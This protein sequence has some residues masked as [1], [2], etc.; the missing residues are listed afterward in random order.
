MAQP[1][2]PL[3][4]P[5]SGTAEQR[6][7]QL[8]DAISRKQDRTSEPIYASVMLLAPNGATWRV[9]VDNTGALSTAVVPR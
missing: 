6:L 3:I 2:A 7:Q 5:V 8:A 4:A 9:S 1:P